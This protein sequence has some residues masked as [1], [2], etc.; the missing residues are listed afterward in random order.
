M[1]QQYGRGD[2]E[3]E[4]YF[5]NNMV[6]PE[7]RQLFQGPQAPIPGQESRNSDYLLENGAA[8]KANNIATLAYKIDRLLDDAPRLAGLRDNVRRIAHPRSA[9]DVVA[10]SLELIG[11]R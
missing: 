11:P 6:T 4:R 1:R 5:D 2:P 8:I 10:S 9:F 3:R 7:A